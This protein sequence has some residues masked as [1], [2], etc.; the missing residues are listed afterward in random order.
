MNIKIASIMNGILFY[1][2]ALVSIFFILLFISSLYC[3]ELDASL[4][5]FYPIVRYLN[6]YIALHLVTL[7][8]H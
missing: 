1:F 3:F 6:T 8:P 4:H 2:I 7:K 5:F